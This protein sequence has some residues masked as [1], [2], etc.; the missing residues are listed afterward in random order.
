[1]CR[2]HA[3]RSHQRSDY[4]AGRVGIAKIVKMIDA[5]SRIDPIANAARSFCAP[6]HRRG[7]Y[8]EIVV[9]LVIEIGNQR[10]ETAP[11]GVPGDVAANDMQVGVG[12]LS[13]TIE[14][15]DQ[16]R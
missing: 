15:S 5:S 2:W 10:L 7:V 3:I 12:C 11:R 9:L 6:K 8:D 14:N 16:R 1:M 4:A 13:R